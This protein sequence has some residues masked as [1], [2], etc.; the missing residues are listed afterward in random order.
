MIWEDTFAPRIIPVSGD[1]AKPLLGL[2]IINFEQLASKIDVIYHNGALVNFVYPYSALKVTN[3][4]GTQEILK[5][6]SKYRAK[7]VNFVSTINT[8]DFSTSGY[9]Q[10][11]TVAEKLIMQAGERGLP[12]SIYRPPGII[13]HSKTG[14]FN[15]SDFFSLIIKGCIQFGKVPIL[16]KDLAVNIIPVDWVS[17][18]IVKL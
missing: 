11:K 3:V 14:M 18:T 1:L 8:I 7:P 9:A 13:G 6:A 4:L 2:D 16:Q 5:L 17:N 12:V 15:Q 10:S